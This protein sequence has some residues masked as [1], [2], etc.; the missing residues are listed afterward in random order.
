MPRDLSEPTSSKSDSTSASVSELVGSSS[1]HARVH[2]DRA[3]DLDELLL[4][5]RQVG[6]L[7]VDRELR[8]EPLL[9]L[10][11]APAARPPVDAEPAPHLARAEQDV[12]GDGE[13][14]DKR[15]L[16]RDGRDP[17]RER[18]RRIAEPDRRPVQRDRSRIRRDLAGE[19]VQQR[20]LPGAVGPD[21]AVHLGSADGEVGAAQRVDAAETLVDPVDA[22]ECPVARH[23]GS[24]ALGCLARVGRVEAA[25]A[26]VDPLRLRPV[27]MER[28]QLPVELGGDL[29]L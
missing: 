13:L 10:G 27:G 18:T 2:R 6:D 20:R 29:V 4:V 17:E 9:D 3:R 21:Q 28:A 22:E 26:G 11:R 23:S 12:L 5:G 16:L 14:R 25:R 8:P 15:R 24:G 1:S 19:D 7:V